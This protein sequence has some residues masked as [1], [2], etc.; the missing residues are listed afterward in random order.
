MKKIHAAA[1]TN[2]GCCMG[3]CKLLYTRGYLLWK[4][5]TLKP[6]LVPPRI[7]VVE[8]KNNNI[9][10]YLDVVLYVCKYN[11]VII[12]NIFLFIKKIVDTMRN[13]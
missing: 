1:K 10:E 8:L 2:D 4:M 12:L 9:N 13:R 5:M 3:Y 6:P 11:I 7:A